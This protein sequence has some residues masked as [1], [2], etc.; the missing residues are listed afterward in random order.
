MT[1]PLVTRA[2]VVTAQNPY[3]SQVLSSY[4]KILNS[5]FTVPWGTDDDAMYVISDCRRLF[6]QNENIVD[7]NEI[8]RKVR[9]AEMRY[10]IAVHYR[11]PYPRMFNKAQG[12]IQESGVSYSPYL[13]SLYDSPYYSRPQEGGGDTA[14][15]QGSVASFDT[16]GL[17]DRLDG[18]G[19]I[20]SR[21]CAGSSVNWQ[22]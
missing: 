3:R 12:S 14:F 8:A 18:D 5:A 17:T 16:C 22:Q 20:Q 2:A 19:E 10:E 13:D 6:R 4:R 7:V 21:R 15:P 11:I 1:T 9:E